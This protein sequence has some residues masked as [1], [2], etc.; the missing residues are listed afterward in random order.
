MVRLGF[1]GF[2]FRG[3]GFKRFGFRGLRVE[4]FYTQ[5]PLPYPS[6]RPTFIQQGFRVQGLGT[7]TRNKQL[8]VQT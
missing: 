4:E 1:G 5:L 3:F 6:L 8:E 7:I 2:G